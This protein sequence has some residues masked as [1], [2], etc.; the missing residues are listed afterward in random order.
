MCELVR[1]DRPPIPNEEYPMS[2][3]KLRLDVN[4]LRVESFNTA[5]NAANRGTVVGHGAC[6]PARPCTNGSSC[7]FPTTSCGET[8]TYGE[9]TCW[10]AYPRTDWR[11]CCDSEGCS[12]VAAC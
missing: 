2:H 11:V 8:E 1:I 12:A 9:Q 6:D 3:N 5:D 10:C 4:A 7:V